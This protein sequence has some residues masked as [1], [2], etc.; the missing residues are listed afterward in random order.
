MILTGENFQGQTI[1]INDFFFSLSLMYPL[2]SM[3]IFLKTLKSEKY[4]NVNIFQF[5]P[6]QW[7]ELRTSI[8]QCGSDTY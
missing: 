5:E 6:K 8:G 2:K 3:K 1:N 7:R 4:E